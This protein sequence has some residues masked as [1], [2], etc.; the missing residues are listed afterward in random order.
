MACSQTSLTSPTKKGTR[1]R[2]K[3][4]N[5]YADQFMNPE[6]MIDIPDN[7]SGSW[8][9]MPRPDGERCLVVASG[10]RTVSRT[11]R[12]NVLHSFQSG[13]PGGSR[14]TSMRGGLSILDCVYQQS[15]KTYYVID[16][17]CWKN[18]SLYDCNTEFR[19]F[20]ASSKLQEV[21]SDLLTR[22][23]RNEF[24]FLWFHSNHAA[25]ILSKRLTALILVSKRTVFSSSIK[26]RGIS[27]EARRLCS[28]GDAAQRQMHQRK[29][30]RKQYC[31]WMPQIRPFILLRDFM[32]GISPVKM[33][34]T[35]RSFDLILKASFRPPLTQGCLPTNSAFLSLVYKNIRCAPKPFAAN[36]TRCQKL[37]FSFS[38]ALA[39]RSLSR[40][41]LH[42]VM[43]CAAWRRVNE[44]H[45]LYVH[46]FNF[47]C[48]L[49]GILQIYEYMSFIYM[50]YILN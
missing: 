5:N 19:L 13:L 45:V 43:G 41:S 46:E 16:I 12:G 39:V 4:H 36:Q 3:D 9:V 32:S 21:G 42:L 8:L 14:T 38:S 15:M 10:C 37:L 44:C 29:L 6:W 50:Y 24:Q 30:V 31:V 2:R 11:K 40:C 17:V 20:W 7:L 49:D 35:G 1:R 18:Y 25:P 26:K 33:F 28:D 34:P 22:S 27:S 23:D 48:N 47:V